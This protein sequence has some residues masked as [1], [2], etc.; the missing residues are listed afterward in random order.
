MYRMV[1]LLGL[2]VFSCAKNKEGDAYLSGE[3]TNP[4]SKYVVLYHNDV[5]LDS[6]GLDANDRFYFRLDEI[7]EG[8][9]YFFHF[10]EYQYVYL[11]KGDS[12]L[13][14]LDATPGSFDESLVFSG[15]NQEINNFLIRMFLVHEKER[16]QISSYYG[17]SPN[18]FAAK[19]DS[20]RSLKHKE[21]SELARN[22]DFSEKAS[23]VLR[24]SIDYDY[25]SHK[26]R[27]PILPKGKS[28]KGFQKEFGPEF[29][30]YRSQIELDNKDLYFYQPYNNYLTHYITNLSNEYC[31]EH[32]NREILEP[33][34]HQMHLDGH[35]LSLAGDVIMEQGLRDSYLRSIAIN[36]LLSAHV[37]NKDCDKFVD[38]FAALCGNEA[39]KDEIKRA[40][41]SIGNLQPGR[42]LPHLELEDVEGQTTTLKEVSNGRTT[43]FYFWSAKNVQHFKRVN[44]HVSE[45]GEIHPNLKFVG[46]SLMTER[47]NW[48]EMLK[49]EGLDRN[50]GQFRANDFKSVQNT[51]LIRNLNKCLIANDTIIKDGFADIYS[52][53]PKLE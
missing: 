2:L 34:R 14:S 51:F 26:E 48:L 22:N 24:A 42:E 6:V 52:S 13:M 30:S 28:I 44:R 1:L 35:R 27:Y 40:Y 33:W 11:K 18:G 29:Y 46:I 50:V 16:E 20:L 8:L 25:F 19:V 15:N 49:M 5:M 4:T 36:F 12:V 21:L 41:H 43:V 32:C 39:Y 3:I 17:L 45:L 37:A 23:A 31:L 38:K 10:P 47:A 53:F 7:E 9:Y